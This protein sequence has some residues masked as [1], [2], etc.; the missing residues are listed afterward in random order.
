MSTLKTI[1]IEP[2]TPKHALPQHPSHHIGS[3]P[4]AFKN[5]WPSFHK[6]SPLN[7]LSS[8]LRNRNFVPVPTRDKLVGI[9]RPDWGRGADQKGAL[10][11]TWIG[12]AS[13]LIET[14]TPASKDRGI[15]I[16]FD[17][18][19]SERT[20]PV[21]WAGPKRF[22]PP[23]CALDELPDVDIVAIS[24]DHYDHMDSDTLIKIYRRRGSGVHFLVPLGNR[25]RLVGMGIPAESV[26]EL[27]WWQ[28]VRARVPGLE[29]VAVEL[30]CTPS[31]HGSGRGILD[32]GSTLWC[33][34]VLVATTCIGDSSDRHVKKL[35]FAGDT[36]YR[37]VPDGANEDDMEHCPAF[38]AIGEA[39]GPFDLSLLPIGCYLP[40]QFLS[41]LHCSPED[42]VC[43]HKDLKSKRSIGMHYG[44]IRG[45]ISQNFEEVTEPPRRFR[46]ACEREGIRWGEE[47]GLLDVGE[48]AVVM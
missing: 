35:F 10:K 27:D 39:F 23:P 8:T 31:Q 42:A 9:R 14:P 20:S 21:S 16:L 44:T 24:H 34:W 29:D 25:A 5:P 13:F 32:Q 47:V 45:G 41:P 37:Y 48:T 30:T 43:L 7:L 40:R 4:T 18:V 11:A 3:P 6:H 33:S 46:E 1:S 2:L 38:R 17:P 12:H 22:T 19:F 28:G 26:T 15:R 36:G